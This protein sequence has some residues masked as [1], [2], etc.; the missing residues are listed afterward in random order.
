MPLHLSST[1]LPSLANGST[2]LLYASATSRGANLSSHDM[3]VI[4]PP[5]QLDPLPVLH[6]RGRQ[7]R[8]NRLVSYC[9]VGT[10]LLMPKLDITSN[11]SQV[12]C[13][14]KSMTSKFLATN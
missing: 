10:V 12:A 11:L 13:H 5:P 1:L 3:I 2:E 9:K 7:C 6:N 4:A 14:T 8:R